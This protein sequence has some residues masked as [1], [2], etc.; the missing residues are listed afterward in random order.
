MKLACACPLGTGATTSTLGTGGTTLVTGGTSFGTA[1]TRLGTGAAA[2][3]AGATAS[4]AGATTSGTGATT[5]VTGGTS[6]GT[7]ATTSGTGATA[8]G[9]GATASGTGAT[10]SGTGATALGTGATWSGT[11]ATTPEPFFSSVVAVPPGSVFFG[12]F[13]PVEC[14]WLVSVLFAEEPLES[15][16]ATATAPPPISRPAV[17]TQ[18]P[19]AKRKCNETTS[20]SPPTKGPLA[21]SPTFA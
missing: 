9:T 5:L 13:A 7:A 12:L 14:C 8:S 11:A 10:A 17:S 19:A 1:A 6:F 4:G 18:T 16:A 15:G 3:G 21:S 20:C 2:S